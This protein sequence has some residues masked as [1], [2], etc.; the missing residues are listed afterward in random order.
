VAAGRLPARL[1]QAPRY[2]GIPRGAGVDGPPSRTGPRGRRAADTALLAQSSGSPSR[3]TPSTAL[4]PRTRNPRRRTRLSRH[5]R[6]D[7]RT[8]AVA[9]AP[10]RA[11]RYTTERVS[12]QGHR[13]WCGI[14]CR[15]GC[16]RTP[17]ALLRRRAPPAPGQGR[18]QERTGIGACRAIADLPVAKLDE[19]PHAIAAA[20]DVGGDERQGEG[21]DQ[22]GERRQV[23]IRRQVAARVGVARWSAAR[24]RRPTRCGPPL[25]RIPPTGGAR[26]RR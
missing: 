11:T 5:P 7:V 6:R 18:V 19:P 12:G 16:R 10:M 15:A 3:R 23:D 8:Q 4:S 21:A 26:S 22:R 9:D 2:C 17:A 1:S 13:H 25:R 20:G 14:T 24:R